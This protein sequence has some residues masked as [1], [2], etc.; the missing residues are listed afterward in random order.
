MREAEQILASLPVLQLDPETGDVRSQ[1]NL[2]N[3]PEGRK[4]WRYWTKGPG[5]AKWAGSAHPYTALVRALRAA[6]VPER[7]VKGLAANMFKAV[8]GI[9]PGERKGKN[10]VGKG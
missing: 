7:S 5:R 10:P 9:W 3:T 2:D 6:G 4:L 8:F 1:S